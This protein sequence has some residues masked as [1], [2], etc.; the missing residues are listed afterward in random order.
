MRTVFVT[1]AS[2]DIGLAVCRRYLDAGWQVI[3][4]FR[5]S[6]PALE[7]L[8]GPRFEPWCADFADT[9]ALEATLAADPGFFTRADALVNLAADMTPVRFEE[10]SAAVLLRMLAINLVPGLLLMRVMEPAMAARGFGRIVHASSIGVKFG[11]GS[12]SFCYSLSKHAQEFIPSATRRS[13]AANVLVNVIRVGVTDTRAHLRFPGK[14]MAERVRLIP[15]QRAAT[16]DEMAETL[17]WFGSEANATITG[18]V[19]AAAGGE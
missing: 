6:R 15:R 12:D 10:V 9:A 13:A 2:S 16:P 11:G 19:I 17:V 7:A 18:Q 8:A 3:G 14:S 1:G 4:H 5:T